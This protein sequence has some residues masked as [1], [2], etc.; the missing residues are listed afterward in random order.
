MPSALFDVHQPIMPT[1]PPT[2]PS[3]RT[4]LPGRLHSVARL[5]VRRT[6][7]RVHRR[8]GNDDARA[9][10]LRGARLL[11]ARERGLAIRSSLAGFSG[12]AEPAVV[13]GG[14]RGDGERETSE[15]ESGDVLHAPLSV[16]LRE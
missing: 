11:D 7:S 1:L 10:G 14:D 15:T 3:P 12:A 13:S 9:R 2:K 16:Q 4:D 8:V 6:K 5:F